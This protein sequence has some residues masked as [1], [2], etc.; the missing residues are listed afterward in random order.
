M[1]IVAGQGLS[2]VDAGVLPSSA[3][4]CPP[5]IGG[6]AELAPGS[7]ILETGL[8]SAGPRPADLRGLTT[9]LSPDFHLRVPPAF[10]LGVSSA[11]RAPLGSEVHLDGMSRLVSRE[12]VNPPSF[13]LGSSCTPY[14]LS[15]LGVPSWVFGSIL[16]ESVLYVRLDVGDLEN[17]LGVLLDV[18]GVVLV[19]PD[20]VCG[21]SIGPVI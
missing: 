5:F 9:R 2:T 13:P 1:S 4:V 17:A 8:M 3:L 12:R 18:L 20:S 15:R 21:C 10:D 6:I 19:E 7:A 16:P 14:K 11:L